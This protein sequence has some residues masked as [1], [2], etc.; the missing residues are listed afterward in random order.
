MKNLETNLIPVIIQH[1]ENK[2]VL[3][4]GYM[5][6]EALKKTVKSK[7]VWFYSR[8][9]KRLWEKGESSGNYLKLIDIKSDC[10]KDALLILAKPAGPTCHTGKDSCFY[11]NT[12]NG[13]K[14]SNPTILNEL[15]EII[16]ERKIN[17]INDSYTSKLFSGGKELISQKVIEELCELIV[18]YNSNDENSLRVIEE[19]C[20]ILFHLMV[21]LSSKDL[22]IDDIAT[23]LENRKKH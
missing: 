10:D 8:S 9:K 20:D 1:S 15:F 18:E 13:L 14:Y 21:L 5:N 17:P 11:N 22:N 2:D 16:D 7:N 23:E 6:N 19:A 4:L 3:M 12:T